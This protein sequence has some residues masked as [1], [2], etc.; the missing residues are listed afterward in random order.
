MTPEEIANLRRWYE[1]GTT[2]E[3][4]VDM[5]PFSYRAVRKT[6]LAEGVKIRPP[7]IPVPPCPPGMVNLYQQDG[8]SIRQLA[9]RYGHSYNQT[10]NMLLRAGVQLRPRGQMTGD[11]K[12]TEP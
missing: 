3:A 12:R 2:I 1:E 4:L 11:R 8:A 9:N 10:R 7:E 5:T 6:L